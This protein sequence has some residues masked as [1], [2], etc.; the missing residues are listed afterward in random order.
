MSAQVLLLETRAEDARVQ[1]RRRRHYLTGWAFLSPALAIALALFVVPLVYAVWISV[2]DW[3]LIGKHHFVGLDNYT[4]VQGNAQFRHAIVFTLIYT[5]ITTVL[6]FIIGTALALLVAR[7]RRGVGLFRTALFLPYVVGLAAASLQ[8]YVLYNDSLGPFTHIL[9]QLHIVNGPV[10]W[11]GTP[12]KAT[13][14][15]IAMIVWK[16]IGFQM[17]VTLVGLQSIDRGLYESAAI[18]GANG[19]QTFRY[20]TLPLLRPTLTLLLILSVT[21][22]LLAFDQ[23]YIMTA[24]GP[25][26]STITMVFS[27]TRLAFIDFRLGAANAFAMVILLALVL[28]NVVQFRTLRAE[29][30]Q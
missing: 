11:L 23:F 7:P 19:I 2:N 3:P 27:V 17:I 21:G 6:I 30:I 28:V 4:A 25:D 5:L 12:T 22:S 16:F 8:W 1:R 24:G 20:I 29:P 13:A 14:S 9:N 15:V 10:D 26:N 18:A